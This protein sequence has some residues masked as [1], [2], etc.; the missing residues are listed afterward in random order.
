MEVYIIHW[1]HTERTRYIVYYISAD[2][3]AVHTI[4][5]CE[6]NTIPEFLIGY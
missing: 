2:M 6:N 3:Y 5:F 1:F 4:I